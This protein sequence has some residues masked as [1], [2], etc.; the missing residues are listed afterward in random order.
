M[1]RYHTFPIYTQVAPEPLTICRALEG[2]VFTHPFFNDGISLAAQKD[3]A[4]SSYTG[5]SLPVTTLNNLM[6]LK[7]FIFHTSHCGSTL[8]AGMLSGAGVRVIKETEAINGLLLSYLLYDLPEEKV[9]EHLRKIMEAYKQ[10]F[11]GDQYVL[12]KLTSWNIFCFPLFQKLYPEIPWLYID[13]DIDAVVQ[14]LL[15]SDGGFAAWWQH[16]VDSVKRLFLPGDAH[17]T[18][19]ESYLRQMVLRHGVHARKHQNDYGLFLQY[20]DFLNAFEAKILPHFN[21]HFSKEA[22]AEAENKRRFDSKKT[23][24]LRNL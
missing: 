24:V 2:S 13:R 15:K 21:L 17:V 6:T 18:D 5:A 16:P 19:K 1:S 8:L 20:P 9:L 7:G 12:F 3:S 11:P 10:P 23:G 4:S 22:L 14:S